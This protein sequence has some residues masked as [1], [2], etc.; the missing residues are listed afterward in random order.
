MA[1]EPGSS[2]TVWVDVEQNGVVSRWQVVLHVRRVLECS[3]RQK[4]LFEGRLE[5][6]LFEGTIVGC[7]SKVSHWFKMGRIISC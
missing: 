1:L 3:E 2:L 7:V 4:F 5:G 6:T